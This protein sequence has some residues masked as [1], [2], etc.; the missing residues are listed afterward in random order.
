MTSDCR[1]DPNREDFVICYLFC[2]VCLFFAKRRKI[3]FFVFKEVSCVVVLKLL[4]ITRRRI[5]NA[6][7]LLRF[8]FWECSMLVLSK[9]LFVF[10]FF[11]VNT[12]VLVL[13]RAPMTVN[14]ITS[15]KETNSTKAPLQSGSQ[16]LLLRLYRFFQSLWVAV[17]S[18]QKMKLMLKKIISSGMIY[19]VQTTAP[20][21]ESVLRYDELVT[22]EMFASNQH[23]FQ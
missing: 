12:I 23:M 20:V 7:L 2:F 15:V 8:W 16:R 10:I 14:L 13:L 22:G 6:F 1:I 21:T 11:V 19:N 17:R 3:L 18:Q 4:S 5:G 9:Q